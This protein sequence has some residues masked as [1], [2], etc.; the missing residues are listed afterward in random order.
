MSPPSFSVD[1]RNMAMTAPPT[2]SEPD[3]WRE[4]LLRGAGAKRA[5]L[6]EAGG[7]YSTVEAARMLGITPG[8]VQ[9]RRARGRLLAVPLANGEWGFP[10]CQ[11]GSAGVVAALPRILAVFGTRDP[12]VQL[13]I[14]LSREPALD[15]RRLIDLLAASEHLDEVERITA[16]YGIQHGV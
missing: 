1:F 2:T 14:L 15:D 5:L 10:V 7:T 6:V 13:S 8:A 4:E 12:W 3:E 9:Q 11:F 16:S